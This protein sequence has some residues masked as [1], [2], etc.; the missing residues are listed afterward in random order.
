MEKGKARILRA[1][2]NTYFGAYMIL[3]S[4]SKSVDPWNKGIRDTERTQGERIEIDEIV[5]GIEVRFEIRVA[6]SKKEKLFCISR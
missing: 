4:N 6:W 2:K 5:G 3:N 1:G